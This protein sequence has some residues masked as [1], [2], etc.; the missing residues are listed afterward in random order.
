MH[1]AAEVCGLYIIHPLKQIEMGCLLS[2]SCDLGINIQ[3]QFGPSAPG[4][5]S[6]RTGGHLCPAQPDAL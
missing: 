3:I 5:K 6:W 2:D 1:E 4:S